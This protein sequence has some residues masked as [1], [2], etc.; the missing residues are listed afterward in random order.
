MWMAI[1][2]YQ[3]HAVGQSA[4]QARTLPPM[5]NVINNPRKL[6]TIIRGRIYQVFIDLIFR[7]PDQIVFEFS[8]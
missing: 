2:L 4:R 5:R 6:A 7:V 1:I 8:I 3:A